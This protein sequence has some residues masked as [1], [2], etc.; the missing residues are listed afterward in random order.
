MTDKCFGDLSLEIKSN[1]MCESDPLAEYAQ[2][3]EP[4]VDLMQRAQMLPGQNNN[5]SERKKILQQQRLEKRRNWRLQNRKKAPAKTNRPTVDDYKRTV[6]VQD[7]DLMA[8]FNDEQPVHKNPLHDKTPEE[9]QAIRYQNRLQVRIER[10]K[11]QWKKAHE[12]NA[13][14]DTILAAGNMLMDAVVASP[15]VAEEESEE[16][17][18][19]TLEDGP[20]AR[21]EDQEDYDY[22]QTEE[23]PRNKFPDLCS[24]INCDD[25]AKA[26]EVKHCGRI[27]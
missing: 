20:E 5:R 6:K 14:A 22:E 16:R 15:S 26:T 23:E 24:K 18:E 13:T 1:G 3:E 11:H 19:E 8:L 9:R 27:K 4:E 2:E 21:S 10:K 25:F 12:K 7:E 17:G